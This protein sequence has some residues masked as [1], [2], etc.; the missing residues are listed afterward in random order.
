[1]QSFDN[2]AKKLKTEKQ[3]SD[4]VWTSNLK[5]ALYKIG[6]EQR[7]CIC[8]SLNGKADYGE[9]LYDLC[10]LKV[11]NDNCDKD[12]WEISSIPLA[13]ESEWQPGL[14]IEEDFDKLVQSRAALRLMIFQS[15]SKNDEILRRLSKRITAFHQSQ[16]EDQYLI[17]IVDQDNSNFS[18]VKIN[19][20][21]D[22][23]G[24]A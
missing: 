11:T 19:G 10:W 8:T 6:K 3:M 23:S 14:A 24:I 13:M 1:M 21:G 9:W 20:L 12:D 22:I 17:A 4:A 2:V 18:F 5:Q 16:P 15:Y 7:Y